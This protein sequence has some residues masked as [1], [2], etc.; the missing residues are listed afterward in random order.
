MIFTGDFMKKRLIALLLAASMLFGL[1]GCQDVSITSD[2]YISEVMS[3]NVTTIAD[4]NGDMCDW[5]EIHNP[6]ASPIS[7]GGYMLT[8]NSENMNKFT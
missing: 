7:L 4:E 6:T 2:L 1:A 8:D 5:I 3:N